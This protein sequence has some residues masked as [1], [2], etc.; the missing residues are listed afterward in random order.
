MS[1]FARVNNGIVEEVLVADQ[2][3]ID[4]YV[5]LSPGEWIK[6]SYNAN[7]RFRYAGLGMTYDSANNV[8]ITAQPFPSWTLNETTW[9]WDSP[10]PHPDVEDDSTDFYEWNEE[11]QSWDLVV[12]E[13]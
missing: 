7:I 11:T 8:F 10:V 6:T 4:N 1:H 9:D 2:D 12:T 13:E 5:S 3:F